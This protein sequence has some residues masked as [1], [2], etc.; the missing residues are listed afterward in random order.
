IDRQQQLHQL[1]PVAVPRDWF[2]Y[3][4]LQAAG[5]PNL[6]GV[7]DPAQMFRTLRHGRVKLIVADNLSLS[8]KGAAAQLVHGRASNAVEAV[9]LY[10]RSEGYITFWPGTDEA[11]IQRWQAALDSMKTD[12]SFSRIYQRWLPGAEEPGLIPLPAQ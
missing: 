7:K 1:G 3:Q 10:R 12:G 11:L 8:A 4:E 9:Y 6:L 2:S 5:M